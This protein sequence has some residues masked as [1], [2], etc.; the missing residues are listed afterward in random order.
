MRNIATGFMKKHLQLET[1]MDDEKI[2]EMSINDPFLRTS[3]TIEWSLWDWLKMLFK[4]PRQTVIVTRIIADDVAYKRW[5]S[6][7][8]A[9]DR[10]AAVIGYPHDGSNADDPGYHHGDERLCETCYYKT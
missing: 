2:H 6:G 3:T 5:F 1:R 8:D 10:C 4:R 7:V 9:C